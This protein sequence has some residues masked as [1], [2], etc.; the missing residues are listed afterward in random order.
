MRVLVIYASTHGETQEIADAIAGELRAQGLEADAVG[1]E[2]VRE[3]DCDAV[4][5]GSAVRSGRWRREAQPLLH[6]FG[7]ALG[8]MPFWVF[9]C[10]PLAEPAAGE[11]LGDRWVE[12]QHTIAEAVRLDARDHAVFAGSTAEYAEQ[13]R[14]W[15][16]GIAHDLEAIATP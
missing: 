11:T 13:I 6:D 15:A 12:S 14:T 2:A 7:D 16:Q 1:A 9:S 8:A 3:L 10:G 5:L 4:I